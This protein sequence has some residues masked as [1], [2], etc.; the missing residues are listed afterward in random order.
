MATR[1][2]AERKG[3]K[4]QSDARDI[5]IRCED[6]DHIIAWCAEHHIKI[7]RVNRGF[8]LDIWRIKDEQQR[9]MFLLKF[10]GVCQ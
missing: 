6:D 7:Q 4:L 9:T 8:G 2:F 1:V 5:A 10:G 3:I